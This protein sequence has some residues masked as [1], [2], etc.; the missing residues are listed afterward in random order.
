[1]QDKG[2]FKQYTLATLLD[3]IDLIECFEAPGYRMRVGEVLTKQ[4][5]IYTAWASNH[6]PDLAYRYVY[7]GIQVTWYRMPHMNWTN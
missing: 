2:L 5:E 1:M 6:P 7:A 4:K 3:Q